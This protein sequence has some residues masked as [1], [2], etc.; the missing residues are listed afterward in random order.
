MKFQMSRHEFYESMGGEGYSL[1][2]LAHLFKVV[3]EMDSRVRR[4][5]I[6]WLLGMG[7]PKERIEGVSVPFLIDEGYRPMNAFIIMDWLT[8]DPEAAKYSLV[9]HA[10]EFKLDEQTASELRA[11]VIAEG[12]I[13]KEETDHE[14]PGESEAAIECESI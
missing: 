13:A 11:V 6:R 3:C 4:W 12:L 10:R 5:T 14:N 9:R 7:L 8:K 2:E 1:Y